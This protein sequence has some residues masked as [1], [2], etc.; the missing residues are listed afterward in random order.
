[1]TRVAE[2]ALWL[3]AGANLA[4]LA[5]VF[6]S[7]APAPLAE[8]RDRTVRFMTLNV[9]FF[10]SAESGLSS[11]LDAVADLLR[12]HGPDVI[13][14]QETEAGSPLGGNQNGLWWLAT[15]SG[16]RYYYG[17]PGSEYTPGVAVLSRWPIRA[18]DSTV[19]PATASIPRGALRAVVEAPGG[20]FLIVVAHIQWA[21]PYL[22]GEP[23]AAY[24]V[25]QT[26]QAEVAMNM[27]RGTLP[28]AVL[29]DFNAGPGYPGPAYDL[30]RAR[31]V[32]SWSAA[33]NLAE[34]AGGFTWPAK[35][36]S[37][38]IDFVWLSRGDW[39][40]SRG[41]AR[42][43]GSESL[44]DHR[45]YVVDAVMRRAAADPTAAR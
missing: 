5:W 33:G 20:D 9:Q 36:P 10:L 43:L 6:V 30:F 1:M 4:V 29:G 28:I 16:Y 18:A 41:S 44:S 12:S 24:L 3:V 13:G 19:L 25:D 2:R 7:T 22:P 42:V 32:D 17:L 34:A 39:E 27:A 21:E 23:T 38:R 26:A 37:M 35:E 40:T 11:N 31:W 8:R 15:R 14:L 45:A